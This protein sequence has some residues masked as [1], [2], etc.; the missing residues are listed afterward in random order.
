MNCGPEIC[1]QRHSDGSLGDKNAER[2][3]NNR[4]L[5]HEVS[6]GNKNFIRNWARDHMWDILAKNLAALCSCPENLNEVEFKFKGP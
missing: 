2:N 6:E 4:G 1:K 3:M 5:A